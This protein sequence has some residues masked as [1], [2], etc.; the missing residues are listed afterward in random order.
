MRAATRRPARRLQ[1]DSDTSHHPASSLRV[2]AR[3]SVDRVVASRSK[4]E[5]RERI[6]SSTRCPPDLTQCDRPRPCP[7]RRHPFVLVVGLT[8]AVPMYLGR[9]RVNMTNRV[10]VQV[11]SVERAGG[12]QRADAAREA[13]DEIPREEFD[14]TSRTRHGRRGDWRGW[15]WAW[16]EWDKVA[17]EKKKPW[18]VFVFAPM[19]ST[20]EKRARQPRKGGISN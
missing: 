12:D 4:D 15:N 19:P 9:S 7:I 11:D 18:S 3:R 14:S 20:T 16:E 8:C 13:G 1:V 5:E 6:S 2:Y 17:K 10:R